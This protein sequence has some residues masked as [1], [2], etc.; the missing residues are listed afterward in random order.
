[1]Q[2]SFTNPGHCNHVTVKGVCATDR[3]LLTGAAYAAIFIVWSFH[4][5]RLMTIYL[6]RL[7]H[8]QDCGAVPTLQSLRT[9]VKQFISIHRSLFCLTIPKQN[10]PFVLSFHFNYSLIRFLASNLFFSFLET[11]ILITFVP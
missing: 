11:Y 8:L 5:T 6:Q 3:G 2:A 1:M 10:T 9:P 4:G 7:I